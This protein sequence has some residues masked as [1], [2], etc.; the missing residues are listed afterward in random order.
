[1]KPVLY[2]IPN[3]DTVKKARQWLDAKGLAYQFHD[4]K[5]EGISKELLQTWCK[6]VGHEVL[7]NQRG[8]TWRGLSEN[9]RT[10]IDAPKALALMQRYPSL[11]KRPVLTAGTNL[12]VGF[13]PDMWEG[14]L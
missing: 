8:T 13:K 2:G 3:C 14:L 10:D 4:Y 12:L 9:E 1:M 5:K 7:L 6:Q 11:I